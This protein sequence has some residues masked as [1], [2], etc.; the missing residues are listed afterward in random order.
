MD[1]SI[2]KRLEFS[3]TIEDGLDVHPV[4]LSLIDGWLLTSIFSEEQQDA[5]LLPQKPK[6]T[7]IFVT[8]SL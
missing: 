6:K 5:H 8:Y 1:S 3:N 4:P 7:S 2:Y